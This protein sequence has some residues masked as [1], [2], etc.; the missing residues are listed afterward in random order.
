MASP[1]ND[2]PRYSELNA[3]DKKTRTV[4]YL[5]SAVAIITALVQAYGNRDLI[6]QTDGITYLDL[7][8]FMLQGR[9]NDA[10]NSHWSPLYP[11][12]LAVTRSLFQSNEY[13]EAAVVK[14]TN[15]GT[16]ILLLVAFLNFL[17]EFLKF[18][19]A[20]R[21]YLTENIPIPLVAFTLFSW[22]WWSS[23]VVSGV[24][25][26]TPDQIAS[27]AILFASSIVL[28]GRRA[29]YLTSDLVF[30]GLALGIG[31]L[32]KAAVMP[33]SL[34]FFAIVFLISRKNRVRNLCPEPCMFFYYRCT[35][36]CH[37]LKQSGPFHFQRFG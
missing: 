14:C 33:V 37:D 2:L 20:Q 15:F 12:L 25:I 23:L 4:I 16:Y 7:S 24:Y 18:Q 29:R 34:V 36:G 32:A 11:A 1:A 5:C 28:K 27:A 9:W 17:K 3:S 6:Y 35:L 10:I 22:F 30:M 31:Y 13:W 19:K 8:N 26:D 21:S